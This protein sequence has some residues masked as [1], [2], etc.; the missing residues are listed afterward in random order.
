VNTNSLYFTRSRVKRVTRLS[1]SRIACST[2][3]ELAADHERAADHEAADE[4]RQPGAR[5]AHARD[6]VA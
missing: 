2:L 5:R 4:Q 6:G 1:A 3:A